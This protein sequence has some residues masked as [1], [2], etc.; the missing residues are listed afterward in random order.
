MGRAPGRADLHLHSTASD[1]VAP[2]AEVARLAAAAGLSAAALTDHDSVLGGA[3]FQSAAKSLGVRP[4]LGVEI[5]G[6]ILGD[7]V[8]LL[9]YFLRRP[10]G[11][12]FQ[13]MLQE[14]SADR[15]ERA[16]RMVERARAL[17]Y[18]VDADAVL[19]HPQVGRPHI[20][21]ELFRLGAAAS[22]SE[23]FTR[24]LSPG[25]P[26]YVDRLRP[27]AREVIAL[28][29]DAGGLVSLAHP[30]RYR[31]DHLED[32]CRAG[33]QAIEVSHPSAGPPERRR[34][35]KAAASLGLLRTGGSDYHGHHPGEAVGSATCSRRDALALIR[36]LEDLA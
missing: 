30:C 8:H 28:A 29:G 36:R 21:R 9:C 33:L 13:E 26:I 4:V 20:A 31:V 11:A 27:Q 3:E 6:E 16:G 17:G 23:A 12:A 19:A 5:A 18:A 7:E 10:R 22:V 14:L 34:L 2:P 35:R 25:G 32:L 15:R 1:G 24:Y